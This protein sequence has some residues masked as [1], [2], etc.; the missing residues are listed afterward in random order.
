MV[1]AM[2]VPPEQFAA[3]ASHELFM[4]EK[5]QEGP[6]YDPQEHVSRSDADR[7]SCPK[8]KSDG[9]NHGPLDAIPSHGSP[10][11]KLVQERTLTPP[12]YP[13]W[14]RGGIRL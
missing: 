3:T 8:K 5:A 7:Q 11:D 10:P 2:R 6:R 4:A 13:G 14:Y 1:A 9:Q 12:L